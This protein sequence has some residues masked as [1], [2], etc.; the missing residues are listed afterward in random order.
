MV[1]GTPDDAAQ[2]LRDAPSA[3]EGAA[4]ICEYKAAL[5]RDAAT[6][7]NGQTATVFIIIA[8]ELES[9][10]K[11]IRALLKVTTP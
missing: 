11:H 1:N 3:I 8:E 7:A 6:R 4:R 5:N 2:A 9:A 10:A